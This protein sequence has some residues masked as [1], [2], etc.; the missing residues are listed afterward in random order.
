LRYLNINGQLHPADEACIRADNRGFRYGYSLFETMLVRDGRIRL[1]AYHWERLAGGLKLLSIRHEPRFLEE[2]QLEASRTIAENSLEALCRLRL[3]VYAG[4]GGLYETAAETGYVIEAF[5]L[6][7]RE[8]LLNEAG[9]DVGIS[10]VIKHTGPYAGLKTGSALPYAVAAKQA[11][12]AGRHDT[13]LLNEHGNL[14]DSTIANIFMI[15][16]GKIHTP[17]LADGCV[18]GV[19]R[20]HLLNVLPALGYDVAVE[21]IHPEELMKAA[22]VFLTNA[23]RGIRWVRSVNGRLFAPGLSHVLHNKIQQTL[24]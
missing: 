16:A 14:A 13:M 2:L 24:S 10:D 3:Q 23:M 11:A 22:C 18:A 8:L 17:P 9:L 5:P 4:D 20:R 15:K 21:S 1:G 7:P 12:E 6:E 19:M